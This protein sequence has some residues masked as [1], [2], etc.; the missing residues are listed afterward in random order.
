MASIHRNHAAID[1][2]TSQAEAFAGDVVVWV[3]GE[4]DASTVAALSETLAGATAI[5]H[6]DVIVDLGGMTFMDAATVGAIVQARVSL[7]ARSRHLSV[8]SP[9]A[10]VARIFDICDLTDLWQPDLDAGRRPAPGSALATWVAVPPSARIPPASA[11]EPS[12]SGPYEDLMRSAPRRAATPAP[13]EHP[14]GVAPDSVPG[15]GR[16]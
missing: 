3:R 2:G 12:K 7:R 16:P 5:D 13:S 1:K 4:H 9:S 10:F 15:P 8:R 6:A 11:P 14:V